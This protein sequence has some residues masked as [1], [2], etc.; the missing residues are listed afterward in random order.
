MGGEMV[1]VYMMVD[2]DIHTSNKCLHVYSVFR[3]MQ[4]N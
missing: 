1:D 4:N 2:D 3:D